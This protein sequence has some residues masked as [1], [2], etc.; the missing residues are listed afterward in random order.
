M[1][2]KQ[3]NGFKQIEQQ[4]GGET[5][6]TDID[7]DTGSVIFQTSPNITSYTFDKPITGQVIGG[8][9]NSIEKTF[10]MTMSVNDP[11]E[12]FET[13]IYMGANYSRAHQFPVDEFA[14]SLI[15]PGKYVIYVMDIAVIGNGGRADAYIECSLDLI[16]D[17]SFPQND[18]YRHLLSNVA[19]NG[20]TRV[21]PSEL[22]QKVNGD[23]GAIFMSLNS[24]GI[25]TE[26][27]PTSLEKSYTI[28]G[29]IGATKIIK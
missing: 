11:R 19:T 24:W 8:V 29:R 10:S 20:L 2:A 12:T 14:A 1:A 23:T 26:G 18:Q 9:N 13:P 3:Y 27:T 6:T 7:I 4:Y 21:N 16:F 25:S 28:V 15:D 22:T 5:F 17:K